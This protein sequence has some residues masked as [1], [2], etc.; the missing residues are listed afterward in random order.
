MSTNFCWIHSLDTN[1]RTRINAAHSRDEVPY[2]SRS[3]RIL[4]YRAYFTPC[5]AQFLSRLISSFDRATPLLSEILSVIS[6]F[7]PNSALIV[8][9]NASYADSFDCSFSCFTTFSQVVRKIPEGRNYAAY[10]GTGIL[11]A[12]CDR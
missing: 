1:F 8:S 10:Y 7:N 9:P 6:A 2:I 12:C 11:F 4:A 3:R 5:P